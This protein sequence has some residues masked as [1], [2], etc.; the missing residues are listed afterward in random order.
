MRPYIRSLAIFV[1]GLAILAPSAATLAAPKATAPKPRVK[2][3]GTVTIA[4]M[5][6]TIA[7]ANVAQAKRQA[8]NRHGTRLY[9]VQAR[10]P[11]WAVT[12]MMTQPAAVSTTLALRYQGLS[13][14]VHNLGAAGSYVHYGMLHWQNRGA[15]TDPQ[16]ANIM[17]ST[18]Q[19]LGLQARVVSRVY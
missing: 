3:S 1:V 19:A 14:H 18:M 13:A 11:N 5:R 17:S 15:F 7:A 9:L 12:G 2:I 10:N 6:N 16:T 4:N 8:K